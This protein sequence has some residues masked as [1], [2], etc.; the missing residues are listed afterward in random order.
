MV[1]QS[2]ISITLKRFYC[3]ICMILIIYFYNLLRFYKKQSHIYIKVDDWSD[4][5]LWYIFIII[6]FYILRFYTQQS[7]KKVDDW[8]D[9]VYGI[10]YCYIF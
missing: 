10:F 5:V 6:Y 7:K 8:H 2:R 3:M 4:E 1:L 9:E